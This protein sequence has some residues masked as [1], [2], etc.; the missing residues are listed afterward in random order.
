MGSKDGQALPVNL[1]MMLCMLPELLFNSVRMKLL[2][3]TALNF[4]SV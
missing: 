3:G 2:K 1:S 4:E